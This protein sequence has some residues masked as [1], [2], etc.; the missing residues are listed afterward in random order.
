MIFVMHCVTDLVLVL[1]PGADGSG[2]GGLD[3]IYD[4]RS[5]RFMISAVRVMII[6]VCVGNDICLCD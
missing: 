1:F 3:V 2:L 5:V 6:A 4:Y